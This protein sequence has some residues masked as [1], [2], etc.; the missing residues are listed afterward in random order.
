M[1][2]NVIATPLLIKLLG[3]ES[4]GLIGFY[5]TLYSV[6]NLLDFGI[7]PTINRELA[8]YSIDEK[9]KGHGRDLVRT[10]ETGYW[11]IGVVLGIGIYYSAPIIAE[12][13]LQ[14][15]KLETETLIQSI[16]LMG[17]LVV[18]EWPITFYQG[19][20]LGLQKHVRLNIINTINGLGK[21]CGSL[22]ILTYVSP[23]I[24]T[25]FTWQ[26]GISSIQIF[27]LVSTVWSNLPTKES[28]PVFNIQLLQNIWKFALSLNLISFFG[29][30]I[31]QVDLLFV[32]HKYTLDFFGYYNLAVMVSSGLTM[33]VSPIN[34]T[35]FPRFSVLVAEKNDDLFRQT[36]HQAC[37]LVSVAVL[38]AASVCILFSQTIIRIW[39][40][41]SEIASQSAAITSIL[42]AGTALNAL[43][44]I[45]YQAQISHG[46]SLLALIT[47]IISLPIII[48]MIFFLNSLVGFVGV[49]YVRIVYALLLLIVI[50]L[51]MFKHILI[52][53][54]KMW[55]FRDIVPAIFVCTG[56]G[57]VKIIT[58][59]INMS[60]L[61]NITGILFFSIAIQI[62]TILS[63]E[64]S[65][66]KLYE[67]VKVFLIRGK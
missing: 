39:T 6:I 36:Y 35:F 23:T 25:F 16:R 54:L 51:F 28:S 45:P 5:T 1:A 29:L 62:L 50:V 27:V 15:S 64:Y 8:K 12:R 37:Q 21:Y 38:P 65:R 66:G 14:T 61:N 34:L 57:I 9:Q 41:N 20:L 53:E 46:W 11:L 59:S 52:G 63:M 67:F 18:L 42:V 56:L 17:F 47:N 26:L 13:W 19:C 32:S 22:L 49:A 3:I 58:D 31:F 4:Y 10:L 33:L 44:A 40:G 30:I 24:N 48:G 2:I 7:S 60:I 43:N 55:I